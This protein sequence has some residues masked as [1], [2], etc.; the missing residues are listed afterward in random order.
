MTV[1]MSPD[2]GCCAA[3]VGSVRR[4]KSKVEM[5]AGT[6]CMLIEEKAKITPGTGYKH[7]CVMRQNGVS[8]KKDNVGNP[9]NVRLDH[10][11]GNAVGRAI[12]DG[13]CILKAGT[14]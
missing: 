1:A 4:V 6:G 12:D 2:G 10:S 9:P 8:T 5:E 13:R 11:V 3:N 7:R 14:R